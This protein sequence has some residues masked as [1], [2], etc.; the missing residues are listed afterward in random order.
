MGAVPGHTLFDS[1]GKLTLHGADLSVYLHCCRLA[2]TQPEVGDGKFAF[3]IAAVIAATGYS[4]RA[5]WYSLEALQGAPKQGRNPRKLIV[6]VGEE[7]TAANLHVFSIAS[8][9]G[10]SIAMSYGKGKSSPDPL[11]K[12]LFEKG[13]WYDDIPFHLLKNLKPLKGAPLAIAITGYQLALDREELQFAINLGTWKDKAGVARTRTFH[14]AWAI[15]EVQQF[16]R[17]SRL[18]GDTQVQLAFYHPRRGTP[19]INARSEAAT[20]AYDRDIDRPIDD[21]ETGGERKYTRAELIEAIRHFYSDASD[22]DGEMLVECPKCRG[23]K[24]GY[25]VASPSLRINVDKGDYGVMYCGDKA[26]RARTCQYGRGKMSYHL[27]ADRRGIPAGAAMHMY[28]DY[29]NELKNGAHRAAASTIN[30]SL[31]QFP[32]IPI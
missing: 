4:E 29:I 28:D 27:L 14:A 7:K 21:P 9:N 11:R 20:R 24:G 18:T 1:E 25:R 2:N 22:K 31:N 5:V 16:I 32:E 19:L 3:T 17:V 10:S 15:P 23:T 8:E 30:E 26:N 12:Y 13:L 6:R